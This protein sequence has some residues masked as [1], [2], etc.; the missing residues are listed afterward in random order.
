MRKLLVLLLTFILALGAMGGALAEEMPTFT[1][2]EL[3]IGSLTQMNGSFFTEM[4]GNNTADIDVRTLLHAY[5]TVVWTADG[6]YQV[7]ETVV[8]NAEVKTDGGNKRYTFHIR[9]GL[10]YNDGTPITAKDYVFSVLLQCAPQVRELG[11][12]TT[13]MSHL[14][15]YDAYQEGKPFSSL[16]LEDEY[17]FSVMIGKSALPYYYELALVAIMPY[18]MS[19][20]APECDIV[21]EGKGCFITGE[22]TAE[23]LKETLFAPE[24]GYCS[25]PA[26]T[27]GPYQLQSYDEQLHVATF[28]KNPKY[29]GNYEG[30]KPEF[31][32][33]TFRQVTND[34]ML[35][36]LESGKVDIINKIA[37]GDSILA[38]QQMMS[39]GAIQTVTY[40]RTGLT[41][42]S[43]CCEQSVTGSAAV[44]RAVSY[45]LDATE[46]CNTTMKGFATPV[47][48]YYGIGQWMTQRDLDVLYNTMNLYEIDLNA[49]E[50]ELINDGWT[51]N[52]RGGEYVKGT[53]TV[54]CKFVDGILTA[55]TL[56]WAKIEN[57]PI[58]DDVQA[59]LE[60]NLPQI[61]MKLEVTE[62]P[63]SEVLRYY[64][65]E[66]DRSEYNMFVLGTNFA[67]VYDPYYTFNIDDRYQGAMN[68]TA[69]RDKKLMD[70]TED[71]RSTA[72]DDVDSYYTK[73][74]KF[75][76]EFA[77][78]LPIVPL[79]S[80]VYEDAY[81]LG[82]YDYA[83]NAMWSWAMAINYV[84]ATPPAPE[85]GEELEF[86]TN[87]PDF[88]TDEPEFDANEQEHN[89]SQQKSNANQQEP[90]TSE[91]QP[92]TN[93][94][95]L[96]DE[97]FVEF[98]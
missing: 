86:D 38:G 3:V 40:P 18:P 26:V 6:N 81:A 4:W 76:Q 19:V 94:Q 58:S 52:D 15:G 75:Q 29:Q 95:Q 9:Q 71:M 49:A 42:M 97:E 20:I 84:T 54:R 10:T 28:V 24:T 59:M 89:T 92:N 67:Q 25:H 65:R 79:Y 77:L 22:M 82:L 44:R 33:L 78:V 30:K 60:R 17:T 85:P 61:G 90:A 64:Y 11:G 62:M 13:G 5:G 69:L 87:E 50:F 8:D 35:S 21:D 36:E 43:F 39:Q 47:Y 32:K 2:D 7:D 41:M 55:L 46:L 16:R 31:E 23:T 73:W 98:D 93:E 53:D 51:L 27:S 14:V 72:V 68:P 88:D 48:G 34:T 91:R 74:L 1:K 12:I 66:I 56:R 45:A 57:N 70:L 63:F 37:V 80:G 96:D 83:P